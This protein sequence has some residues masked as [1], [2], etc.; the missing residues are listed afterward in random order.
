[1]PSD[2]FVSRLGGRFF[3]VLQDA[4]FDLAGGPSGHWLF[5]GQ[6]GLFMDDLPTKI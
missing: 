2:A 3:P 1:M 5:K 6:F 4:F